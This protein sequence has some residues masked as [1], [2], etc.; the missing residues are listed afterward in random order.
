MQK[1]YNDMASKLDIMRNSK[2]FEKGTAWKKELVKEES[3][4]KLLEGIRK[5]QIVREK[6]QEMWESKFSVKFAKTKEEYAH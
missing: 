6:S 1:H 4:S 3:N 2:S 5:K